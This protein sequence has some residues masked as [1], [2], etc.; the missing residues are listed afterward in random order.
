MSATSWKVGVSGDWFTAANWQGGVPTSATDVTIDAFGT[1]TVTLSG[2]GAAHSL[3]LDA[4]GATFSESSSGTLIVGG[5]FG[6]QAGTT[7]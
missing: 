6:V 2:A 7:V 4:T 5:N 3:S 1:Y